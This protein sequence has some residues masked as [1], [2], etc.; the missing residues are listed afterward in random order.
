LGKIDRGLLRELES[1]WR[2]PDARW[3]VIITSE[4]SA[5]GFRW[6]SERLGEHAVTSAGD[7]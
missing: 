4:I 6:V 7:R 5:D 1:H 2:W 3:A